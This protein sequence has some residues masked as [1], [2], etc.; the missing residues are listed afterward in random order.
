MRGRIPHLPLGRGPDGERDNHACL[1]NRTSR[2]ESW[3]GRL[4]NLLT[5]LPLRIG[6][7]DRGGWRSGRL[8]PYREKVVEALGRGGLHAGHDMRIRVESQGDLGMA[9]TF[10]DDFR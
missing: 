1:L 10:R 5:R 3:S 8:M 6:R 9:K 7:R 2:F 4:H